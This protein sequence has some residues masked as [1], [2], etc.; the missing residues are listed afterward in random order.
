M[1]RIKMQSTFLL[2]LCSLGIL[3]QSCRV[4]H[5]E[6][7][8]LNDAVNSEKRVKIHNK[9]GKTLKFNR[10]EEI[11]EKFYGIT[12]R[13]Y[14]LVKTEL[15][16]EEL[17]RVRLQNKTWSVVYGIGIG[18]VVTYAVAVATLVALLYGAF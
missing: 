7:V 17:D 18:V 5:H 11:D 10:I 6:S 9:N 3:F 12:E 14:D 4:Y 13:R 8:A 15:N 2:L 1:K 16:I